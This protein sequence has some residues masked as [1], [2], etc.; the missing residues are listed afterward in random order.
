MFHVLEEGLSYH[1]VKLP[2][3]FSLKELQQFSPDV[4]KPE[5]IHGES[6]YELLQKIGDKKHPSKSGKKD[7][8]STTALLST[9]KFLQ[10]TIL[11]SPA[12]NIT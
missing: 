3:P 1:E 5:V 7:S 12:I 11:H 2:Q 6:A 8:F 9:L 10:K 4:E